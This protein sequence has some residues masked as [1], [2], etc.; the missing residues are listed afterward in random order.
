MKDTIIIAT[1]ET[2]CAGFKFFNDMTSSEDQPL[3]TN[4]KALW[5]WCCFNIIKKI[6]P[7]IDESTIQLLN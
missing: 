3:T 7:I 5:Y 1:E 6:D 2:Q 4:S